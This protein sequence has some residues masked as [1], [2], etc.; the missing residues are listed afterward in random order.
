MKLDISPEWL[1]AHSTNE[2]DQFTSTQQEKQQKL[3]IIGDCH[4]CYYELFD[5]LCKLDYVGNYH[6]EGRKVVFVG[7]LIDRGPYS[8]KCLHTAMRFVQSGNGYMVMGNHDDKLKRYLMGNT[9]TVNHGF[10]TTVQEHSQL[11]EADLNDIKQFLNKQPYC[12]Y[13]DD[14]KLI[15]V[16]AAYMPVGVHP[17][18][19]KQYKAFKARCIYGEVLAQN[20]LT[21]FPIRGDWSIRY[22]GAATVVYGHTVQPEVYVNNNTYGIDT[23]AVFGGKLTALRYPEMEIVQVK[24]KQYDTH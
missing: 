7:D 22:K 20:S 2:L 9:V 8:I 24:C 1:L 14:C 21:G 19:N 10:E 5:L 12:L 11:D 23:G 4:A 13:L 16:H 3:D 6:P 18:T 17:P 15:V